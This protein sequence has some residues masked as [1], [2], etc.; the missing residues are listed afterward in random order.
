MRCTLVL[1]CLA[2]LPCFAGL[3]ADQSFIAPTNAGSSINEC[4]AFTGQT[5]TAGLTAALAAV[6]VDITEDSSSHFP[7]D[8]QIRTVSGGLPTTTVL[9]EAITTTF[10]LSDIIFFPQNIPQTAGVQ[11]AII[12]HF[13]GAP[14]EGVGQQVGVWS[15]T[16]GNLYPRGM[17]VGSMDGGVTWPI[18]SPDVD[19][20]FV[21]YV[22]VPEPE[23]W[24][25][26]VWSRP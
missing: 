15:G 18:S 2:A 25:P 3:I 1:Y 24:Y 10:G 5:Y 20:H 16:G 9:G 23:Y 26:V 12:V 11:Y 7:L 8:V 14:P 21:T 4:C 17:I 6:S 13:V 19:S 22:V